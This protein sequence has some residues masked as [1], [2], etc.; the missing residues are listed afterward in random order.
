MI[1]LEDR[2]RA[3][4]GRAAEDFDPSPDLADRINRRVQRRVHRNRLLA[5]AAVVTAVAAI[6]LGGILAAPSS[7]DPTDVQTHGEDDT[8]SDST[9]PRRPDRTTTSTTAAATPETSRAPTRE[10]DGAGEPSGTG[11]GPGGQQVTSTT[12]AVPAL[13][14]DTPL[15]RWGIGPIRAGMSIPEAEAAAGVSLTYDHEGWV[16]FGR[17]CGV[18]SIPGMNHQLVAR[19]PSGAPSD[20]PRRDAVITAAWSAS[21]RTV[22][23]VGAGSTEA[24]IRAAYGGPTSTARDELTDDPNGRVLLY[25]VDGYAY[26]F[27][28]GSGPASD[29]RSGHVNRTGFSDFEPCG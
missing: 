18:F 21:R 20:N 11:D 7:D 17:N 22:D 16:T 26:G 19:T 3:E 9:V 10:P 1:D 2:L 27:R 12:T 4:I 24:E 28:I 29:V 5:V 8:D 6:G 14:P 23:G 15:S 13:G 25:E